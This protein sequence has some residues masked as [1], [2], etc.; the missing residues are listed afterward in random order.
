MKK[1]MIS[2]LMLAFL[3]ALALPALSGGAAAGQPKYLLRYNHVHSENDP[4]HKAW[5]AWADAVFKRT[6]GDVKIDVYHSAQLGIEEDIIEQMRAGAPIAQNSDA[7]RM[8]NY[9]KPFAVMNCPYFVDNLE[10]VGKLNNLPIVKEW[11]KELEDKYGIHILSFYYVQGFREFLTNVPIKKP[12]DLKGLRIRTAPAP[13][14]QESVRALGAVPVAMPYTEVYSGIQTK[15]VDGCENV[16]VASYHS[17]MFEVLKYVGETNHIL[18]LNFSI[19][20]AD[21]FKSL[22][23]EYQTILDE[24]C[25]KAGKDVSYQIQDTLAAE[26]KAKLKEKGMTIINADELDMAAFR[27]AGKKA[28]EVLGLT[29]VRKAVYEQMGKKM[30]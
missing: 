3:A 30:P 19:T 5:L 6:N 4:Y 25:Q 27:E 12:E 16:Y 18:L 1:M 26:A 7:A 8:G 29:D 14:W 22:P 2:A 20:S 17:S 28:Y 21:W 24:E 10:E 11:K 9:V 15:A 23:P 13:A